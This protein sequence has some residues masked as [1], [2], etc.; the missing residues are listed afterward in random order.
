MD[1]DHNPG[2]A[3]NVDASSAYQ[4]L[5]RTREAQLVDVRTRAEWSF[6]GIPDL[7]G[8]GKE[9]ILLEWQVW[10]TMQVAGDFLD[11][12]AAEL[13]SR[14]LD[15]KTPLY[16]LC[17]SGVRSSAAAV[18]AVEAGFGNSFNISGGFEGPLNDDRHRGAVVGWKAS[19]LPW[20]QS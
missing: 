8:M 19:G 9:P 2:H 16:F 1:Q 20:I 17:R 5:A 13:A 18:A 12:L 4:N 14:G 15:E 7:G 6:V 11:R 10:P 3:G